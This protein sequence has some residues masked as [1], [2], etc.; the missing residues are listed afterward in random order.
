MDAL[1]LQLKAAIASFANFF[2]EI[3]N[4]IA[5]DHKTKAPPIGIT[6]L[7]V[8]AIL[9]AIYFLSPALRTLIRRAPGILDKV[10]KLLTEIIEQLLEALKSVISEK[11]PSIARFIANPT[12]YSRIILWCSATDHEALA[13]ATSNNSGINRRLLLPYHA[14]FT[15]GMVVLL[16]SAWSGLGLA[17]AVSMSLRGNIHAESQ[18][19]A[20]IDS[21]VGAVTKEASKLAP[22]NCLQL[23]PQAYFSL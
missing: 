20:G 22:Q 23:Q 18:I 21:Q 19:S 13:V 14:Q 3:A 9:L 11:I 1:L 10:I 15:L 5:N 7:K 12:S 17:F 4:W 8:A 2:I 16:L 6:T